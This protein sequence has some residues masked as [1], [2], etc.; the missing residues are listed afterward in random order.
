MESRRSVRR[1]EEFSEGCDTVEALLRVFDRVTCVSEGI[2]EELR[3]AAARASWLDECS[4]ATN[5]PLDVRSCSVKADLRGK[6]NVALALPFGLLL[7][8]PA[9]G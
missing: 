7:L 3:L 5:L 6:E 2:S 8:D 4:P 9:I 1:G